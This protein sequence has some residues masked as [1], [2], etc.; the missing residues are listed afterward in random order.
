MMLEQL[1]ARL[2]ELQAQRETVSAQGLRAEEAMRTA[3]DIVIGLNGS[4]SEV[5][6][7]LAELTKPPEPKAE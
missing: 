2:A 5:E 6:R 1:Q 3:R 7:L 4:I